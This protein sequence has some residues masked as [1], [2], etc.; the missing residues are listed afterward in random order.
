MNYIAIVGGLIFGVAGYFTIRSAKKEEGDLYRVQRLPPVE[1]EDAVEGVP[2]KAYGKIICDNPISSPYMGKPC[3]WSRSIK[4]RYVET[5]DSKGR[6][7]G[8]WETVEDI[9][10]AT[11]FEI[12]DGTGKIGVN[13]QDAPLEYID[14]K[15]IL[16]EPG[17]HMNGATKRDEYILPPESAFI[18]GMAVQDGK[19][20]VVR[21]NDRE[22]IIAS[23]AK[24]AEFLKKRRSDDK[25]VN[26]FGYGAAA[27]GGAAL[28]YGLFF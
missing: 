27:I 3:V 25:F 4:Q 23:I 6:K 12:D 2:V 17:L 20:L 10:R 19:S 18:Y 5:R 14:A 8:H 9:R 13:L 24:E 26:A 28:V 21:K 1:L 22:P 7:S 16:D 15:K 11:P